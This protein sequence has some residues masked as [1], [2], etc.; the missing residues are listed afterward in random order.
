M[1]VAAGEGGGES[2]TPA[3]QHLAVQ[4]IDRLN[5]VSCVK[6]VFALEDTDQGHAV[7]LP[8][9]RR[10]MGNYLGRSMTTFADVTFLSPM[11]LA[12]LL[13]GLGWSPS[14]IFMLEFPAQFKY[15]IVK[16]SSC[17]M[18]IWIIKTSGRVE[19]ESSGG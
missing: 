16:N 4:Q 15:R 11:F 8:S 2:W 18:Y 12:V 19:S 10:N 7:R 5:L 13:L 17:N 1:R 3:S 9:T 14:S 6:L